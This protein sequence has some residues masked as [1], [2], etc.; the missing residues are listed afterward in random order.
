M[1]LFL[2]RVAGPMS[3]VPSGH[4]DVDVPARQL[5][6]SVGAKRNGAEVRFCEVS[7]LRSSWWRGARV[8]HQCRRLSLAGRF[9][10]SILATMA[11]RRH[12]VVGCGMAANVSLV[13]ALF[14]AASFAACE[15]R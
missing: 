4:V 1:R 10:I 3:P 8:V 12:G 15:D 7:L 14:V 11:M 2:C 13:F 5:S 6:A 9:L